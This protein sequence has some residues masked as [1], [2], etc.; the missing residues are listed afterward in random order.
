MCKDKIR[1]QVKKMKP[2]QMSAKHCQETQPL[3]ADTL[4][5]LAPKFSH[6]RSGSR[7]YLFNFAFFS[8]FII[9]AVIVTVGGFPLKSKHVCKSVSLLLAVQQVKSTSAKVCILPH[10]LQ[11]SKLVGG[12]CRHKMHS[13]TAPANAKLVRIPIWQP[14]HLHNLT[15]LHL[16]HF[17]VSLCLDTGLLLFPA[18]PLCIFRFLIQALGLH[19]GIFLCLGLL[20]CLSFLL[21][22]FLF[23]LQ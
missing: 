13:A 19:T 7:L 2:V 17:L 22:A 16:F 18:C 21:C 9:I 1:V 5:I 12:L 8:R 11:R 23:L 3:P 4:I 6:V 15:Y 20:L 10:V 14:Y